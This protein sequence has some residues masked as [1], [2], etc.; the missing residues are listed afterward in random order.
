[1]SGTVGTF[2]LLIIYFII[3]MGLTLIFTRNSKTKEDFLVSDRNIGPWKM[4]LSIAA[5]WIWA[6][7]LFVS[8]QYAY[9]KGITGFLWFFIPNVLTL[10][11]FGKIAR[12]VRD[13]FPRGFT[14]AGFFKER[15]SRKTQLVSTFELA[16]LSIL[17]TAVQ[18]VAGGTVLHLLAPSVPTIILSIT[19]VSIAVIYSL[20]SGIR[21]SVITDD[22]QMA[23]IL[24][25]VIIF[26]IMVLATKGFTP[27]VAG[28]AGASGKFG[29][30]F[31]VA[32]RGVMMT[33][34]IITAIGLMSGPWGDQSF[35]QRVFS[36]EKSK[37]VTAFRWAAIQFAIVP[38]GMG[39]IGFIAAGSGF[40]PKNV[41]IANFEF[42]RALFPPWT[43]YVFAFMM[44]SGLLST[45]DSH[46]CAFASLCSDVFPFKFSLR[47]TRWAMI[48]LA[49]LSVGIASLPSMTI[50]NLFLTYGTFRASVFLLTLLTLKDVMFDERG[51]IA[52]MITGMVVGTGLFVI[53]A[54]TKDNPM[55]LAGS[56]TAFLSP[57]II[58]SLGTLA[59]RGRLW[60]KYEGAR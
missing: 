10:L 35:W 21:A 46:L 49:L 32:G 8:A 42:I 57:V 60:L 12:K 23:T 58:A 17:S 22:F 27:L 16:F 43:L 15:Y 6:P 19:M 13:V 20:Y 50:T 52:G 33:F 2:L 30:P 7:A 48:V 54:I 14:I 25:P 55:R 59:Y 36:S 41:G 39:I 24:I 53:G 44:L 9:E 4:S 11:F 29:N 5:T 34:G 3:V 45:V 18:L 1:M 47:M 31:S 26:T 28:L 56:L 51:F 37:I 38:I 40:V